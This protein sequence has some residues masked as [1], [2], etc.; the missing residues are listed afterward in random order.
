[1]PVRRAIRKLWALRRISTEKRACIDQSGQFLS[2]D[3]ETIRP[4][5]PQGCSRLEA[6]PIAPLFKNG[7]AISTYSFCP[8]RSSVRIS[9]QTPTESDR[10]VIF[11]PLIFLGTASG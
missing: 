6:Q 2:G 3:P 1:M 4:N 7:T 11:L 9:T 8:C 10:L 5:D